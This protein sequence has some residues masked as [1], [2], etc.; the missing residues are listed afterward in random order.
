MARVAAVDR[1]ASAPARID[2]IDS[3]R[4]L[5]MGAVVAEHCHILPFGWIGVWLFFVI[6]G[7]VVTTSLLSQPAGG[8][9]TALLRKF[10]VRRAARIWPIYMAYVLIG[11]SISALI[12]G[13]VE[14]PA[15]SS[16]ML[17]YNNFQ[18]AFAVGIFK[19]FPVGHL[20]TISVEFQFYVVFGLAFAFLPRKALTGLLIAFLLMSPALRFLGGQWLQA[21][22]YSPLQAA[23]AVYT[24]SPM[25]FDSFAAGALLALG[26]ALW[27]Q[28]GRARALLAA[29]VIGM[30]AY[31]AAYVWIN[32]R[33][34]ATGLALLRGV[35]SGV[36]FGDLKQVWLYS[37]VAAVSAGC[38]ATVLAGEKAWR[39]IAE[40]R[41]LRMIGRV[42]YGGYVYHA[43]CVHLVT[44][45]MRM[46]VSPGPGIAS[47]I[48]FGVPLFALSLPLTVAV[49]WL[50]YRYVERPIIAAVNLQ[51]RGRATSGG[52][53]L[54]RVRGW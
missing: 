12:V 18:S 14:W 37:A 49:A 36:L 39:P 32:G 34:G 23:F 24:F 42:S 7:F 31:V 46:V 11:A 40:S 1:P 5:A 26:R 8:S 21:A 43:L 45:A 2:A 50:S 47:K 13:G 41:L 22:G 29:G 53:S 10:Y 33:H 30:L 35:I 38:L 54:A 9:A 28:P 27:T 17:F 25:H 48:A 52:R 3:L 44:D 4:A 6:S 51:L 19:A 15:L 16:L 20:W